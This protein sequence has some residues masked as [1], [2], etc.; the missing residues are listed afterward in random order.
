MRVL[1]VFVFQWAS[2]RWLR[3]A[4]VHT[5]S[6]SSRDAD[7][8]LNEYSGRPIGSSEPC[9]SSQGVAGALQQ[10]TRHMQQF[11]LGS[12]VLLLSVRL[13]GCERKRVPLAGLPASR[14]SL[15]GIFR[16]CWSHPAVQCGDIALHSPVRPPVEE[17]REFGSF[18]TVPVKHCP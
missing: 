15:R 17:P 10:V 2:P 5:I 6:S 11:P 12:F 16:H 13:M 7:V 1:H 9:F 18:S 8:G 4:F 3:C 14:G